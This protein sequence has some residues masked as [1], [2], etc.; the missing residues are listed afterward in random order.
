[1]VNQDGEERKR[2][3]RVGRVVYHRLRSTKEGD[4]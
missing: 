2:S 3:S 4:W 1:M